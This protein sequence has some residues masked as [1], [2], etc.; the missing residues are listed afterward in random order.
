[1]DLAQNRNHSSLNFMTVDESVTNI[2]TNDTKE[3]NSEEPIKWFGNKQNFFTA[4]I[5]AG[6]SLRMANL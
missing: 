5:I 3:E 4:G 2:K 1:M 6:T